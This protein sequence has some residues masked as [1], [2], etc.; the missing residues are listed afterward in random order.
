MKHEQLDPSQLR[1]RGFEVLV[2]GLGWVNAVRFMQQ[3]ETSHLNY[4]A[5][6]DAILSGVAVD[7]LM[8][9]MSAFAREKN[10]DASAES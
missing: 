4:M 7:E 5:E 10:D 6:R 3:Y 2:R 1:Q 8:R 9:E